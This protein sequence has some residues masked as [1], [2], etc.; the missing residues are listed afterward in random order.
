MPFSNFKMIPYQDAINHILHGMHIGYT[1]PDLEHLAQLA[2]FNRSI[3]SGGAKNIATRMSI[4]PPGNFSDNPIKTS[5]AGIS[6]GSLVGP[7]GHPDRTTEY[8]LYRKLMDRFPGQWLDLRALP[9]LDYRDMES[10]IKSTERLDPYR[11]QYQRLGHITKLFSELD[12]CRSMPDFEGEKCR[13]FLINTFNPVN[14]GNPVSNDVVYY[15][16]PWKKDRPAMRKAHESAIKGIGEMGKIS[17]G[18]FPTSVIEE[19]RPMVERLSAP[20]AAAAANFPIPPVDEPVRLWSA[21]PPSRS[22]SPLP[23]HRRD[24]FP[25]TIE[26]QSP[27]SPMFLDL[28]RALGHRRHSA[29]SSSSSESDNNLMLDELFPSGN[30]VASEEEL[31]RRRRSASIERERREEDMLNSLQYLPHD[32]RARALGISPVPSD[33]TP[34]GSQQYSHG[35]GVHPGLS[36]QSPISDTFMNYLHHINSRL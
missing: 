14:R 7:A 35:G 16:L 29:I 1:D 27:S 11:E 9:D 30:P 12:P 31:E 33:Y 13:N 26:P 2:A 24:S 21:S 5:I 36:I 19:W 10:F 22:Q 3:G 28:P 25:W 23:L 18:I 20:Q 17:P 6:A 32:F 8:D 15:A 4:L 34:P